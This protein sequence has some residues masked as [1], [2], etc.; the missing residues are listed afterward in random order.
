MYVY[1]Y[2]HYSRIDSNL[3]INERFKQTKKFSS[4]FIYVVF[5]AIEMW[6]K[7]GDWKHEL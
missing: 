2:S 7:E 6:C 3:R 1:E 5:L 4:F